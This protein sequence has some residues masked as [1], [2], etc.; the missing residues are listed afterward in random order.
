V[1]DSD[2]V[3]YAALQFSKKKTKR[4]KRH[5]VKE[6]PHVVY[7]SVGQRNPDFC[8]DIS[9]TH[10][11]QY[12]Y[13]AVGLVAGEQIVHY[14][15]NIKKM[16]PNTEWIQKIS[17]D[18]SDYWNRETERTWSDQEVFTFK[19]GMSDSTK[20]GPYGTVPMCDYKEQCVTIGYN[21]TPSPSGLQ[22]WL[23]DVDINEEPPP[24]T[25]LEP[26]HLQLCYL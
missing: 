4:N 10:S 22:A 26:Q 2:S 8:C 17:A 23:N 15:S 9:D 25:P 19:E 5:D 14:E 3:N 6:D 12:L 1:S 24:P 11:L 16:I 20:A 13:T 7:S 21:L 18:D